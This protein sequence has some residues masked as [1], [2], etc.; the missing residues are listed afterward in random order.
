MISIDT[1]NSYKW[2]TAIYD[3]RRYE[4]VNIVTDADRDLLMTVSS[5]CH[6]EYSSSA[7]YTDTFEVV[8]AGNGGKKTGFRWTP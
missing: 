5:A 8:L 7:S 6:A 1:G 4:S 2:Q 3:M